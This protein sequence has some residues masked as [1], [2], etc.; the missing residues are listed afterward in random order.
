LGTAQPKEIN[1]EIDARLEELSDKIRA[2]EPVGMLEA[3]AA[4]DYQEALRAERKLN[5]L[6]GRF[7]R[8]LMI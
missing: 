8:W 6:W 1:V 7:V 5:T 2:G 4:I 3:I